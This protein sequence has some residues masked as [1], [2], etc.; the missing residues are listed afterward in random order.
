MKKRGNEMG[1]VSREEFE[2]QDDTEESDVTVIIFLHVHQL[3][4]LPLL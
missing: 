4:N 3:N 2:A 1:Q